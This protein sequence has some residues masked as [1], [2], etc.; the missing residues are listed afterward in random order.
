MATTQLE[1][2]LEDRPAFKSH[3]TYTAMAKKLFTRLG[4]NFIYS[5][6]QNINLFG[7]S[8][9]ICKKAWTTRLLTLN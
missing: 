8:I 1:G 9:N 2:E 4:E 3:L 5:S 7:R 6:N